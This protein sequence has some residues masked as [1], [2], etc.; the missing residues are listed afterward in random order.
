MASN[1]KGNCLPEYLQVGFSVKGLVPPENETAIDD[2]MLIR[3]RMNS[4]ETMIFF[5]M[6]IENEEK[7]RDIEYL[8]SDALK[9]FLQL[10]GLVSDHY[11]KESSQVSQ[12]ISPECLFGSIEDSGWTG[13]LTEILSDKDKNELKQKE[14]YFIEQT[15]NK[16]KTIKKILQTKKKSFLRNAFDY[17]YRSLEEN[18]YLERKFVDLMIAF[19]YLFSDKNGELTLRYS[20]RAGFLLSV[21]KEAKRHEVVDNIKNLYDKRSKLLH[22]GEKFELTYEDIEILRQYVKEA[23]KQII[24]FDMAKKDFLEFL[25]ESVY[26]EKKYQELTAKV[27]EAKSKW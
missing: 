12:R 24:F 3:Q 18:E 14:Q 19:E 25:D 15:I 13:T 5:K 6:P 23:I 8:C 10:Y 27:N 4:K 16:Y 21:G 2:V 26:N 7:R 1:N 9:N 17:Y 11:A 22:G 20:L